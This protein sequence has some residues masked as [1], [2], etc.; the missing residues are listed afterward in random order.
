MDEAAQPVGGEATKQVTGELYEG[1]SADMWALGCLLYTMLM[2]TTPF[3]DYPA[4]EGILKRAQGEYSPIPASRCLTE[5][6]LDLIEK[7]IVADPEQRFRLESVQAHPWLVHGAEG[8]DYMRFKDD[9]FFRKPRG[10]DENTWGVPKGADVLEAGSPRR[11]RR[12][13]VQMDVFGDE[14]YASLQGR[15][16]MAQ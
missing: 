9:R 15:F 6:V 13:I 12:G 14:V 3:E 1:A 16:S 4:G 8:G 7:L 2:A 10:E 5:S 11:R